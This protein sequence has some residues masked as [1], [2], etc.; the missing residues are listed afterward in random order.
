[1][2]EC[3]PPTSADFASHNAHEALAKF[4]KIKQRVE[5]LHKLNEELKQKIAILEGRIAALSFSISKLKGQ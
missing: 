1:M 2:G 4:E 5:E 3:S